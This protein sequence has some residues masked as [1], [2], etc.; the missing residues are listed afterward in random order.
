MKLM[1]AFLLLTTL[2]FSFTSQRSPQLWSE[3][4][5][6]APDSSRFTAMQLVQ[7][8]DEPMG[9]GILPNNNVLI[10]ERKGGVR[11]YDAE[12][13]QLKT[14]AHINVF[15]GIED[16]LLGWLLIRILCR[17][18]GFIFITELGVKSGLAN[19]LVMN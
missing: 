15:S 19:W 1:N 6:D 13:K 4:R 12:L 2:W 5:T 7:G 16:G 3:Q 14:I 9:M 18:T 8:L 11:L 17:T 10:V